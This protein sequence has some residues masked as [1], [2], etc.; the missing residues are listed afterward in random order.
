[1]VVHGSRLPIDFKSYAIIFTTLLYQA[2]P[3]PSQIVAKRYL[4]FL[5]HAPQP[6]LVTGRKRIASAT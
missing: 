1:M 2:E 5:K 3:D 4:R 6:A